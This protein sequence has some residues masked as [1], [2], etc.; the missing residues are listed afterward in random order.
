MG[1][2]NRVKRVVKPFVNFPSWMQLGMLVANA[3]RIKEL[4]GSVFFVQTPEKV[5]TFE[6]AM[7]R[8]GLTEADLNERKRE[9][10]RLF[11]FY[12][13]LFI[14]GIAYGI[15]LF[16][17]TYVKAGII[18]FAVS[19][20]ILAQAFRQHFWL[21]QIKYRLLGLTF[22]IWFQMTFLGKRI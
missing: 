13:V 5:E 11:W 10:A 18:A 19:G 12:F 2:F 4:A 6:Q 7:Q 3:R 1:F 15:Y 20:I 21:T 9:F 8:L 22:K 16:T 14:V 17:D